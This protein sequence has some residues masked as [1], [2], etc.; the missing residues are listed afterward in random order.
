MNL[1]DIIV[2]TE[3]MRNSIAMLYQEARVEI[4]IIY[5]SLATCQLK[6]MRYQ[7]AI[8]NLRLAFT[9]FEQD[10]AKDYHYSGA[11]SAM[12]EAQY[13]PQ[14]NIHFYLEHHTENILHNEL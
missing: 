7:E 4:A 13:L 14:E 10:E 3:N 12:G 9:L 2:K 1:L 11:L 8:E 5:T 6:L